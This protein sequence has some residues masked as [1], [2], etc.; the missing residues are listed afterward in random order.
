M[1][2]A[3]FVSTPGRFT[4]ATPEQAPLG[5]TESCAAWLTRHLAGRG[6]DVTLIA[7]LPPATPPRIHGVRHVAMADATFGFFRA[8]DFDAVIALTMPADAQ[9]LKQAAPRAFHVA[10]LHLGPWEPALEKLT[11]MTPFIDC[12]VFV[13]QWQREVTRFAGPAHVIGNGIAPPFEA[14]FGSA[15]ELLAAKQNRAV[16]CSAP[17]RGL[18]ILA[19]AFAAA[20]VETGLEV[21]SGRKLYQASD[22]GLEPLYARLAA[23]PRVARHQPVSQAA[24]A[25][26]LRGAA[27]LTYPA[28]VPET[29]CI[30]ALEAM[31]AGLKVVATTS[32]ALPESTFGFADLLP[33]GEAD[34]RET[35]LAGFTPLIERNVAEFLTR[36]TEWAEDRFAQSR[37]VSQRCNWAARAREWEAFLAP[38]V[39]WKRSV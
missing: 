25:A 10:W 11:P 32:G 26:A 15:A 33:I 31:A 17:E 38:A 19:D 24:L 28:I 5:G 36:G 30:V 8:E 27:F 4:A 22:A 12:A 7:A 16:Y 18:E 3:F 20:R 39:A 6:H 9:T 14:M 13:S 29:F 21:Y 23:L 35:V 2:L 1:K 37:L 34:S